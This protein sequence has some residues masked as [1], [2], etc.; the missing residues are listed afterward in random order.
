MTIEKENMK[1]IQCSFI[2]IDSNATVIKVIDNQSILLDHS[3]FSRES[4]LQLIQKNKPTLE[5]NIKYKLADILL[6]NVDIN[7][8]DDDIENNL[9]PLSFVKDIVIPPTFPIFHPLN[10]LYVIYQEI[11]K[12]KK[13]NKTKKNIPILFKRNITLKKKNT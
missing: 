8:M 7:T 1:S 3:S 10:T 5:K 9:Q 4:L 12:G 11:I 6:Y 2:Y 13:N